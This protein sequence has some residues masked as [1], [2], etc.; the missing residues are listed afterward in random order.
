MNQ[1]EFGRWVSRID[2]L[3]VVQRRVGSLVLSE[4]LK[5]GALSDFATDA[6]FLHR[7]GEIIGLATDR[8]DVV[9]PRLLGWELEEGK[10]FKRW[11]VGIT[12]MTMD[13]CREALSAVSEKEDN[14]DAITAQD[15]AD[16][17]ESGFRWLRDIEC[18]RVRRFIA[19]YLVQSAPEEFVFTPESE[20]FS[21]WK[22]PYSP[23]RG[24]TSGFRVR[25]GRLGACVDDV[26]NFRPVE[27]SKEV[28][29]LAGLVQRIWGGGRLLFLP[30]GHV[31]KP[32]REDETGRR[33]LIGRYTGGIRL[34]TND[35][36]LDLS[37]SNRFQ[38]GSY[39]PG[40]S[41]L[42]LE[43][44][45]SGDG[46]LTT[47]WTEPTD[48]GVA[49]H[50]ATIGRELLLLSGFRKC[51]PYGGGRVRITIGRHA[52]TK[53]KK[54][55]RWVCCYVGQADPAL[56]VNWDRWGTEI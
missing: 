40:P 30:S 50:R 47:E 6:E 44:Y 29:K 35:T 11:L 34:C 18:L 19:R 9:L 49:K 21:Y 14:P 36:I 17:W 7:L 48:L 24:G 27:E 37:P 32:L 25:G 12:D 5:G 56:F 46:T 1:R 2:A 23:S 15:V 43:C 52:I 4:K 8:W 42:G 41:M 53:L 22:G 28:L 38:E 55:S 16:A 20:P 26:R 31:I 54:G 10:A 33:V 51:R 45:L 13:Q 39:W 3:T